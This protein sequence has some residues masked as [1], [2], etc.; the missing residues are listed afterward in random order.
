M[1]VYK[2]ARVELFE[3]DL[4]ELKDT[5]GRL[6]GISGEVVGGNLHYGLPDG[7]IVSFG[8]RFDEERCEH[9][10]SFA[11]LVVVEE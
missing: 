8:L 3:A 4:E 11:S 2:E 1:A 10:I 5:L 7:T 9:V 6:N